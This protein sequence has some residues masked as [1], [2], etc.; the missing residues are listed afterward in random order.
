MGKIV[1]MDPKPPSGCGYMSRPSSGIPTHRSNRVF[2][3]ERTGSP[4]TG[5]KRSGISQKTKMS[6]H[7]GSSTAPSPSRNQV[8]PK[9]LGVPGDPPLTLTDILSTPKNT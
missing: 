8:F 3:S 5:A 7:F 1:R 2:K 4:H 9:M 6:V